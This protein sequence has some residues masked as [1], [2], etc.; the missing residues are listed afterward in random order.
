MD[1]SSKLA[2]IIF[3]VGPTA[4]GKSDLAVSLA[5]HYRAEV[6]NADSIQFYNQIEV[7]TAKPGP[8]LTS[9]ATHHLLSFVDPPQT[10]SAGDFT[11]AAEKVLA[12]RTA[13]GVR[14]F[15]I[16]GGSGFYLQALEK[17]MILAPNITEKIREQVKLKFETEGS[18]KL[19]IE[20][21]KRDPEYALKVSKQDSYRVQRALEIL[22][23]GP[24]SISEAKRDFASQE[25]SF[26][27]NYDIQKIALDFDRDFLRNRIL[28]RT[29]QMLANQWIEEVAHLRTLGFTDWPPLK[30]VGYFEIGE[31]LDSRIKRSELADKIVT[32]TQ[33]LAKKQRT[34]F[35]RDQENHWILN[36]ESNPKLVFDEAKKW[37][38]RATELD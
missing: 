28:R 20:V 1:A 9:R 32:S 27:K 21:E 7:G 6:I 30:S 19:W 8:E 13:V 31:F 10:L 5:E 36:A 4:T 29:E 35:K 17:G 22:L 14:R 3:V 15:I 37:L 12:E 33:Q 25:S 23:S 11:R 26:R 2:Q 24:T 16:V 34:W 38:G 18:E